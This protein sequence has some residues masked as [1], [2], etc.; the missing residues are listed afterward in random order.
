MCTAETLQKLTVC[1]AVVANWPQGLSGDKTYYQV[2]L[3]NKF[4]I[5]QYYVVRFS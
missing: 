5:D 2:S 4:I 1:N 3:L